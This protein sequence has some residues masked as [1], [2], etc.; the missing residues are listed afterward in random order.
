MGVNFRAQIETVAAS[1]VR[2]RAVERWGVGHRRRMGGETARAGCRGRAASR[3]LGAAGARRR[4]RASSRGRRGCDRR[5]TY[6]VA[7]D[8]EGIT[9]WSEYVETAPVDPRQ[10]GVGAGAVR[11]GFDRR[12]VV[13]CAGCAAR[14]DGG[15]RAAGRLGCACSSWRNSISRCGRRM[16]ALWVRRS[17]ALAELDALPRVPTHGDAHPLNLCGRHG[18]GR[19]RLRLGAVRVRASWVRP[20][21]LVAELRCLTLPLG[22]AR[23]SAVRRGAVLTAALTAFTG[24]VVARS[25]VSR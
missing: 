15:G 3:V 19:D 24:G 1:D 13:G 21:V 20:R 22:G 18:R 12:A 7:R 9:V 23:A 17:A 4:S 8:A 25:V 5:N 6:R 2:Y 16:E 10:P 14:S 11:R